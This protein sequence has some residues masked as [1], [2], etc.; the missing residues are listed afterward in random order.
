MPDDDGFDALGAAAELD[1]I[2][3]GD[4]VS[5]EGLESELVVLRARLADTETALRAADARADRAEEEISRARERLARDAQLEIGRGK[6]R[7]LL[8]L[9]ELLDDLDRALEAGDGSPLRQG[10]ELVRR[11]PLGYAMRGRPRTQLGEPV[12]GRDERIET[13]V[14]DEPRRSL[15][16]GNSTK[17][18]ESEA[19]RQ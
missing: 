12:T 2:L 19:A 17:H 7:V 1:A 6:Q 16:G 9:I 10:I 5:I 13:C 18:P 8:D 14:V 4:G 11:R 15:V 3:R